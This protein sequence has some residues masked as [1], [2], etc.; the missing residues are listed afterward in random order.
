ML[1]K[2][3]EFLVN[4]KVVTISGVSCAI[5]DD[6][7]CW[8]KFLPEDQAINAFDCAISMNDF[9]IWADKFNGK[10]EGAV[11]DI[12]VVEALISQDGIYDFTKMLI[13]QCPTCQTRV[14]K[15]NVVLEGQYA[16]CPSCFRQFYK[17]TRIDGIQG[18]KPKSTYPKKTGWGAKKEVVPKPPP[19]KPKTLEE[20]MAE[21]TPVKMKVKVGQNVS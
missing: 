9:G 2:V 7:I 21:A 16:H 19:P 14:T 4:N 3:L 13:H 1:K 15:D 6:R 10:L 11:K 18:D 17:A 12:P 8:V 20:M 5:V